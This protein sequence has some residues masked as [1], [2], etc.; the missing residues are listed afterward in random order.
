M[1]T[2]F[3]L[4]PRSGRNRTRPWLAD[5]I[6]DYISSRAL[7][8]RLEMTKGAGHATQLAGEAVRTGHAR[9]VAVGGDGTMNEVAQALVNTPT[10]LALVP[11]GS[12]NGLALHLGL[13]RALPPALELAGRASGSVVAVDTATVN[14]RPFF[15]VMGVGLDADVSRRFNRLARRGLPAYARLA[16]SALREARA[17]RCV[18]SARGQ[19]H[20]L[21]TLL[22]A[23][24][25]SD[26]YGNNARIA[27]GARVDDGELDLVAVRDIGLAGAA[28]LAVRLFLGS[29]HR[30]PHVVRLKGPRFTIERNASGLVHTDGET[31]TA[32][33]RLEIEIQAR[34]LR[35]VVP[36]GSRVGLVPR[37][38]SDE[39]L[40]LAQP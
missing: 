30:S 3:I 1:K 35:V 32:G 34:S 28:S 33:A 16:W 25:N 2:L 29:V 7:D 14:G 21:D 39:A 6:R 8:A 18:I 11:C 37:M 4:N 40:A 38:S 22:V 17:E 31:H 23:I 20:A 27:P 15:N 19:T 12:G 24:A 5:V 26:Q 36:D 13:P 10:A 9:V